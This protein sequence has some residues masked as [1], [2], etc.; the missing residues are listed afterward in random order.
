MT[1]EAHEGCLRRMTTKQS[2]NSSGRG[3]DVS[4][5]ALVHE[6][7]GWGGAERV[8]W[9]LAGEMNRRGV[10][11]LCVCLEEPGG[12]GQKMRK[13]GLRVAD[14]GGRRDRGASITSILGLVRILKEFRPDVINIHG[15]T[16]L[17]HVAL[18]RLISTPW[19]VVYTA[20]GLLYGEKRARAKLRVRLAMRA[21]SAM[22]AVSPEVARRNARHLAWKGPVTVIPNGVPDLKADASARD[23][24]RRDL[25]ADD[26]TFV[27]LLAGNARPEKG[28]E[29]LL[30]AAARLR[31][32]NL[33]RP[34]TVWIAGRIPET[35]YGTELWQQLARLGL[36]DC[37]RF[38]GFR[39][40]MQALYSG[41]DAFVLCSRS[42][43]L[44]MVVLEAMT[45]ALPIVATRVGG[46]PGAVTDGCG[47]L[48]EPK[49]PK[50]LAEAMRELLAAPDAAKALGDAARTHARAEYSVE[51]MAD[52][53]LDVMGAVPRRDSERA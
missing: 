35:S 23:S 16:P 7:L 6:R 33:P 3:R 4:R 48:V 46:V 13:H 24:V 47:I 5:V 28:F 21:V 53:Y 45:A 15:R 40:D 30:A 25:G 20:H 31:D 44:P 32:G 12:L 52:A 34:F 14:L 37:V 2:P 38:L 10:E 8:I 50:R 39:E 51:R 11:T 1:R 27:F 9:H 36:D 42:E 18:A 17:P 41:A 49:R 29:D 43:G 26:E 19:P 22:T